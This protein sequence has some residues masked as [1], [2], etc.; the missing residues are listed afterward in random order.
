MIKLSISKPSP[1]PFP[2]N[3]LNSQTPQTISS[4]GKAPLVGRGVG[5][6]IDRKARVP[7]LLVTQDGA[8]RGLGIHGCHNLFEITFGLNSYYHH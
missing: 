4:F 2:S 1:L 5:S 8:G 6:Q 3:Q 7:A